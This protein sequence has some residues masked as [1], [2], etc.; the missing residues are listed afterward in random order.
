MKSMTVIVRTN[1]ALKVG[2]L[3]LVERT[4]AEIRLP[5][6]ELRTNKKNYMV[7]FCIGFCL[8][9]INIFCKKEIC[10]KQLYETFGFQPTGFMDFKK[11]RSLL[12]HIQ[13]CNF[14]RNVSRYQET[15]AQVVERVKY[16]F[17]VKF[18]ISDKRVLGFPIE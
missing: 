14:L 8:A 1:L 11:L 16:R 18:S 9:L 10:C 2:G 17:V 15:C 12:I 3:K 13:L 4:P 5:P 6:V 7:R